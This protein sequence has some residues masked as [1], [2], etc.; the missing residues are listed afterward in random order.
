MNDAVRFAIA[1]V[2][3]DCLDCMHHHDGRCRHPHAQTF[4]DI[5]KNPL[6]IPVE[7]ER[8]SRNMVGECGPD[9]ENFEPWP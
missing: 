5:Y 3:P 8:E 9:G 2:G 6:Y 1:L 7:I 4:T